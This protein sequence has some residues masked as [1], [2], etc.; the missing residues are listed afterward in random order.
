[1]SNKFLNFALLLS[2]TVFSASCAVEAS[3]S[4]TE[5]Q[6]KSSQTTQSLTQNSQTKNTIEIKPDSPADTVRV[7]YERLR[8]KKFRDAIFLTNLRPA[9]EGLTDAELADLQVDFASLAEQVPAEL[10]INGEII[11]GEK[12]TVTAN[13]PDG[14]GKPKRIQ[15]IKLRREKGV[16]IILTLD[17]EAEKIVKK[18]GKNYFFAL[19]IE[20]HHEETQNTLE[21]I[22][23]AEAAYSSQNGGIYADLPT[24]IRSSLISPDVQFADVSGYR[25]NIALSFDAKNYTATAEPTEY[26]KTGVLSFMIETQNGTN[27]KLFRN[28]NGGK[29]LK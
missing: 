17:G 19:K 3:K 13:L 22:M 16:W 25:F 23:K 27:P 8:G 21:K 14:E 1:M 20:T 5:N 29:S 6:P 4:E 2:V 18:E 24:L 15:E 12:A 7:F 11:T 10:E 28:D 26:G 9:I